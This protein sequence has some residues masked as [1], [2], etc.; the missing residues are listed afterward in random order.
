ME[1]RVGEV[2]RTAGTERTARP[3][4]TIPLLD[5]RRAHARCGGE[6]HAAWERVLA[7]MNLLGGEEV[8]LFETEFATYL[9]THSVVGVA[10]GTDALALALRAT[11]VGMGDEVIIQA[12][13]FAADVEGI[14][15]VDAKPIAVDIGPDSHA[16]DVE[17]IR[18][19]LTS[20]T[21]AI[22]LVHLYGHPVELDPVLDIATA[23]GLR[24]I[25]DAS[26]AH[27]AT[28]DGRPVGTF[29][30]A[31]AF[32]LGVVKNLGA[33]GDAGAVACNAPGTAELVRLLG[34]HGQK[35]KNNHE[36]YGTNSRLD[37]LLAAVLR[38]KLRS[39]D[40]LNERRR[41]IA[42]QYDD[43]FEPLGLGVPRVAPRCT[44]VYHQY[45]VRTPERDALQS[46][47]KARG[48]GTGIHYPVPLHRQPAWQREYGEPR[49]LP[50]AE[51]RARE[52]LSLPVF[53]DL[54]DDEVTAVIEAVREFFGSG[55]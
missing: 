15:A 12:N 19:A 23:H 38:I 34:T 50:H 33:Y 29:G 42:H 10:S 44:H 6:I 2:A 40:A 7:G 25:E 43:A 21:R 51:Q 17:E 20:R 28:Y 27:G 45:V 30:D 3:R 49:A 55:S 1:G 52:I 36:R 48:I 46:H 54:S 5:L 26:H 39:L 31:G 16:P 8:R 41:Q 9:G 18:R 35:G 32:S 47:L 53:P 14:R 13:A 4:R 37:E 11:G 24:V 22:L